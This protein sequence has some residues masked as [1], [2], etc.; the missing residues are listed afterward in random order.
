MRISRRTR[1]ILTKNISPRGQINTINLLKQIQYQWCFK[2]RSN[3]KTRCNWCA[4]A[5]S[6]SEPLKFTGWS[7][8]I[9]LYKEFPSYFAFKM[10]KV[11][12]LTTNIWYF[13]KSFF[14]F[15]VG[16]SMLSSMPPCIDCW[17]FGFDLDLLLP[18]VNPKTISKTH[19]TKISIFYYR[20]IEANNK[21]GI[22]LRWNFSIGQRWWR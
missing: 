7:S 12:I 16:I 6:I 4:V 8:A 10:R 21:R 1:S 22:S 2:T 3:L 14:N 11:H 17:V 18:S 15:L 20:E 9:E 5:I 19:Q 13:F